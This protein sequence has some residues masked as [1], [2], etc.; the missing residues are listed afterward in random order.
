MQEDY[1]RQARRPGCTIGRLLP[2]SFR[3]CTNDVDIEASC[4]LHVRQPDRPGSCGEPATSP[5]K[6]SNSTCTGEDGHLRSGFGC[7]LQ[8]LPRENACKH[9]KMSLAAG[10]P[11]PQN[12]QHLSKGFH[13]SSPSPPAQK[14]SRET[15]AHQLGDAATSD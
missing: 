2:R 4:G 3:G 5:K 7:E 14:S 1:Y 6:A 11:Q 15:S 12:R 9:E 8:I 13:T 10:S